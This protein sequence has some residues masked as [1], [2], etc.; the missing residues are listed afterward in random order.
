MSV[1]TEPRPEPAPVSTIGESRGAFFRRML[2]NRIG[3]LVAAV[4]PQLQDEWGFSDT[5]GGS[6]PTASALAGAAHRGPQVGELALTVLVL[7][8]DL[9]RPGTRVEVE[10]FGERLPA[11]V[12]PDAPLWDPRNERLRA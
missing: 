2:S 7:R 11:T 4:L 10:V 6:I 9:A 5:V 12:Q 3:S 1:K 8:A